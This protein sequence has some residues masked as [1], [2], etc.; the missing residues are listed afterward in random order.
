MICFKR[1]TWILYHAFLTIKS[2]F[3]YTLFHMR[4]E[5]VEAEICRKFKNVL[6]I[7]RSSNSNQHR[8]LPMNL[9]KMWWC[10][11]LTLILT[12]KQFW[13]LFCIPLFII[14]DTLQDTLKPTF[15]YLFDVCPLKLK[16]EV[17]RFC[18]LVYYP[19]KRGFY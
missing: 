17:P 19:E 10:L 3:E 6:R 13:T 9:H 12:S 18:L 2:L 8:N 4:Y 15:H 1:F 5:N 14:I 7:S 16:Q 11:L